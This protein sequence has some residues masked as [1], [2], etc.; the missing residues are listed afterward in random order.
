M[1]DTEK[2]KVGKHEEKYDLPIFILSL[3]I[4]IVLL[5]ILYELSTIVSLLA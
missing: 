3:A 1:A 4:F 5:G 2:E